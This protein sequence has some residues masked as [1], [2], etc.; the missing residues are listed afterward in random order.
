MATP[1][2]EQNSGQS[3]PPTHLPLPR[4]LWRWKAVS[5]ALL[6]CVECVAACVGAFAAGASPIGHTHLTQ[7]ILWIVAGQGLNAGVPGR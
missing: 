6:W 3:H 7:T 1:G 2:H 4:I 5:R